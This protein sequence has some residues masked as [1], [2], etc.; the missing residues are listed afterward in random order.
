MASRYWS[1]TIHALKEKI[2]LS[3]NVLYIRFYLVSSYF[4]DSFHQLT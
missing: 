2:I 1:E 3:K 4:N